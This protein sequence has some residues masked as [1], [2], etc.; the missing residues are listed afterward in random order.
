MKNI[1]NNVAIIIAL[2]TLLS[3][4]KTS[5]NLNL[6]NEPK[7]A[8]KEIVNM[9]TIDKKK[10]V[11]KVEGNLDKVNRVFFE[12]NSSS[13]TID[14]KKNLKLQALW[15]KS[16]SPKSISVQGHCDERG[17]RSYNMTLGKKRAMAVKKF[18]VNEG[19]ESNIVNVV[20]YGEDRPYVNGVG[21]KFWS[22]NRN[23]VTVEVK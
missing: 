16:N 15:I 4:C 8:P 14:A 20:S 21:E 18:L 19:I 22:Q 17:S 23:A 3:S 5:S 13:L 11:K 10:E 1:K 9:I 6:D 2:V 7:K 12:F